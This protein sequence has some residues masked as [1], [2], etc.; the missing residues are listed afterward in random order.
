MEK[1]LSIYDLLKNHEDSSF[2]LWVNSKVES[3]LNEYNNDQIEQDIEYNDYIL[4]EMTDFID[5]VF[6]SKNML[7]IDIFSWDFKQTYEQIITFLKQNQ[8]YI[9]E[10]WKF[11]FMLLIANNLFIYYSKWRLISL[12][13]YEDLIKKSLLQ[14]LNKDSNNI[15]DIIFDKEFYDELKES[16]TNFIKILN[17]HL[18]MKKSSF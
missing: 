2:E 14:W 3:L 8:N 6:M 15:S 1:H 12:N 17:N 9:I 18:V 16:L 10:A 13:S 11:D 4:E 7:S 5:E